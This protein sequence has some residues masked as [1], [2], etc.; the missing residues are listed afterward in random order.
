MPHRWFSAEHPLV[1]FLVA[2]GV[3]R[4]HTALGLMQYLPTEEKRWR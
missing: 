3:A 2:K 4:P 1:L